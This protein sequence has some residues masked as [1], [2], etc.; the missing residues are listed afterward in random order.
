[1]RRAY[2]DECRAVTNQELDWG[3]FTDD[4]SHVV[5]YQALAWL[6]WPRHAFSDHFPSG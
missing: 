2:F 5:L 3:T 4:L 6:G 1:M